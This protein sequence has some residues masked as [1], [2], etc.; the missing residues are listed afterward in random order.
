VHINIL[1]MGTKTEIISWTFQTNPSM[2][3]RYAGKPFRSDA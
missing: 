2:S 3:E 1:K